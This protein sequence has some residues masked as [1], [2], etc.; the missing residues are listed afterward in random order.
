VQPRLWRPLTIAVLAALAL[1]PAGAGA[2]PLRP[3]IG[4]AMGIVPSARAG[5]I[6]VGPNF[7]VV[8]HGG[9][10]MS[11]P[12][13]VHTV[14]WAPAG[15]GFGGSPGLGSRAYVP[16][17]EQFLT[18]AAHDSGAKSNVFSVL[19]EYPDLAG[20][21]RYALTYNPATD[22]IND[23]NPYPARSLQCPSPASTLTCVT[24]SEVQAELD[25]VIST[26]DPAGRGLRDVWLMLLPPNVDECTQL[27]AC[28]TNAFLGYHGLSNLGHGEVVYAVIINPLVELTP[29][30][31]GD[32]EGNPAAEASIGTVAHELVEAMSD[33]DGTGWMD[34]NGF[35]NGDKCENG[36]QVG[37]PLGF[38]LNGSPYN[39]LINR[40]EYLIQEMWSNALV[41]CVQSSSV[42]TSPLPLASVSISQYAASIRGSTGVAKAGVPVQV[43]LV[44]TGTPVAIALALTGADGSWGPVDLQSMSPGWT[45]GFGDDRDQ[46]AIS[47]GPGGPAPELIETGNGGNPF[48]E[49]GWTGWMQ[50]DTGFRVTR[51]HV[52]ISPCQQ[53]GVLTLTVRSRPTASPVSLCDTE[54]NTAVVPTGPL[55]AGTQLRMSSEDNRGVWLGNL[56]GALVGLTV[57]LGEPGAVSSL[58]NDQLLFPP[59]GQPHCT[60]DLRAQAVSCDGLVPR[61]AYRL[62][63]GRDGAVLA[64]RAKGSGRADFAGLRLRRGESVVLI[65]RSGRLLTTLHV[66][67]LRVDIRGDESVVR[68]GT[69]E[70]GDYWGAP[71]TRPPASSAV[72][73]PGASGTGTICPIDGGARGL[74]A[75]HIEQTDDLSGGVTRTEVPLLTG[76]APAADATLYGPFRAL[77]Q[78]ALSGPHGSRIGVSGHVGLTITPA[79]SRHP[80]FR[81]ADV[82]HGG[83]VPV[84]G[85]TGGVYTARWVVTDANGDTRTVQTKFIEAG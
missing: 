7:Q 5:D 22:S 67:H 50:L 19:G 60:A 15:Y 14:F 81:A 13:H 49:A 52:E 63:F 9:A 48:A 36:P 25:H 53:T 58:R 37:T 26:H 30:P 21:G 12:V 77:A 32:P 6:A 43:I 8:Y 35:E 71:P 82:N 78:I 46:I 70:P 33:P 16:L 75:T 41:G 42:G 34:P 38:A 84:S 54:S 65:N 76:T 3:R 4:P 31:G 28:G 2:S 18:D 47:Y 10:V 55:G 64:V 57:P 73:A 11:A 83:G 40:H 27:G 56:P 17:I 62:R 1:V 61:A 23:T 69:C 20:P 80:V 85:L 29:P 79:G 51:K 24:D 59:S 68:G 44:R 39:Q 66:A 74:S 72:G 45:H